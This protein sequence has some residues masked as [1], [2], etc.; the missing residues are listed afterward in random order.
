M[1]GAF[2]RKPLSKV[3]PPLFEVS[4]TFNAWSTVVGVGALGTDV[5]IFEV[6]PPLLVIVDEDPKD[7]V[8][9]GMLFP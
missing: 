9:L 4:K 8:P 7:T 6:V 3:P 1:L 2:K 5:V